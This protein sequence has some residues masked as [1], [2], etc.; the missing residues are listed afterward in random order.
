MT[1]TIIG[2]VLTAGLLI[3]L[4]MFGGFV[5][6]VGIFLHGAGDHLIASIF[7]IITSM[8]ILTFF[9]IF[10][11]NFASLAECIGHSLSFI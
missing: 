9:F 8:V 5:F 4:L 6:M 7:S 3:S 1:A 11:L 10:V 2:Y